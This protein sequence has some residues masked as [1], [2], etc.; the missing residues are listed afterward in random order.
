MEWDV[1]IR[2]NREALLH[3]VAILFVMAGLKEDALSPSARSNRP[4][5]PQFFIRPVRNSILRVLR[6]AESALR[7]LIVIAAR[8][9]SVVV[10]QARKAKHA[11]RPNGQPLVVLHNLDLGLAC[12]SGARQRR[13]TDNVGEELKGGTDNPFPD[14]IPA[15]QLFDPFKSY[16][17]RRYAKAIPRIRSLDGDWSLPVYMRLPERPAKSAPSPDDDLPARAVCLRLLAVRAALGDIDAE[18][19][20]LARWQARR[21]R[22]LAKGA[23]FR[24]HRLTP[25]RPGYPPG[26]RKRHRYDVDAV[27]EECQALVVYSD[28]HPP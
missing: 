28:R 12:A 6:P 19:N 13:A 26:R 14:R 24:P 4:P 10:P 5:L 18:A 3:V 25:L 9:V 17:R 23:K 2:R 20:R 22:A 27:L 21:D 15:F 1:A 7:R 8:G 11:S 16:G